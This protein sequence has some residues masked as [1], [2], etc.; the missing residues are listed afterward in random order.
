MKW[1]DENITQLAFDKKNEKEYE[2]K[3]IKDSVVDIKKSEARLAAL[4]YLILCKTHLEEENAY[5]PLS[6]A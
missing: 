1:A 2:V 6:A 5:K 4:Y 3:G